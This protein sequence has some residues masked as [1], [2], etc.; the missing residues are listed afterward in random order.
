MLGTSARIGEVLAIRRRDVDVTGGT[1]TIRL[2]G[3]IISRNGE[4]TLRQDHPKTAKSRRIVALPWFTAEAVRRRLAVTR[5]HESN[6]LLFQSRDGTPLTTTNVRRQMRQVLERGGITGI[7]LHMFRRTVATAS[8]D[9]ESVE[10][11]AELLGH[12]DTK[13]TIQHYIR[14]REL[15]NPA[16]AELLEQAFAKDEG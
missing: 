2:A 15:V 8:N 11:A 5:D 12:T 1:P 16:T 6:A 3:T 7:T 9:S 13:I 14:R 10:L 4:A